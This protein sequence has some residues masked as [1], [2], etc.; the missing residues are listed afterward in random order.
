MPLMLKT[1]ISFNRIGILGDDLSIATISQVVMHDFVL[2][3]Y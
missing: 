1:C 2:Q 3:K